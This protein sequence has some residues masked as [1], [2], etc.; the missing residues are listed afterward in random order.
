[1]PVH[2]IEFAELEKKLVKTHK[3]PLEVLAPEFG[4][5]YVIAITRDGCPACKRQK[6][7]LDKLAASEAE[8]HGDKILFT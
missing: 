5:A 3:S 6:P 8:K 4:K 1:M 7:R 2:I